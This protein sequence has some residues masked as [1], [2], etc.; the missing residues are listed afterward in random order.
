MEI[1]VY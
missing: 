1:G